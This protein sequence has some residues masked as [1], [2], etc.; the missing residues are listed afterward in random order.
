M[1]PVHLLLLLF[2]LITQPLLAAPTTF[3]EPG[4]KDSCPVCGM[5]VA[6][7]PE[8]VALVQY[9]NGATHFF[10]G[11]KDLFKY[12]H[13]MSKWAPGHKRENITAI[14]VTDYYGV[15][16]IPAR[17]AWYAI[18]SDVLGP[19]GHELVP[20]ASK[21]DAEEFSR[22]HK[23]AAIVRFDQVTVKLLKNIEKGD[24]SDLSNHPVHEKQ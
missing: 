17:K 18:G 10:D 15:K 21:Q 12:L 13:N 16:R 11:A 2:V 5:F 19:M 23:A 9:K 6:K 1:K 14:A 3:P 8:W 24:F 22:D 20:F 4:P 7:Y